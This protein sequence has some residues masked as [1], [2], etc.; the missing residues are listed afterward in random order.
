MAHTMKEVENVI[1]RILDNIQLDLKRYST[2]FILVRTD[3]TFG[4]YYKLNKLPLCHILDSMKLLGLDTKSYNFLVEVISNTEEDITINIE[5]ED[6]GSLW[7]AKPQITIFSKNGL[8]FNTNTRLLLIIE[9]WYSMVM[10]IILV[11]ET[12]K[13]FESPYISKRG[14]N[15]GNQILVI[16][17][18]LRLNVKLTN[19]E[20]QNYLM[21]TYPHSIFELYC[22]VDGQDYLSVHSIITDKQKMV[23]LKEV[24]NEIEKN[25]STKHK[26]QNYVNKVFEKLRLWF[27]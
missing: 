3:G 13:D 7:S 9:W 21:R 2:S 20:F 16:K 24:K 26:I 10:S 8:D 12:F 18:L 14:G 6:N 15:K 1:G 19:E 23:T 25:Y 17:F 5:K 27:K 22:G 11:D 4:F